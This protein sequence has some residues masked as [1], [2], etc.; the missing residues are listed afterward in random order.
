MYNYKKFQ[1]LGLVLLQTLHN[2]DIIKHAESSAD[3]V[4]FAMSI[5]KK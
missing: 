4:I 5:D 2:Y 1:D 3:F